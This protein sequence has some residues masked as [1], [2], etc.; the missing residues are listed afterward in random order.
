MQCSPHVLKKMQ[1]ELCVI[2]FL[3]RLDAKLNLNKEYNLKIQ[4]ITT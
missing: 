1:N 2:P 3:K 4:T